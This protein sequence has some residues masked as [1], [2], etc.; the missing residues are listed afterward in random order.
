MAKTPKNNMDEEALI[1]RRDG[2]ADQHS[3]QPLDSDTRRALA[4]ARLQALAFSLGAPRS[5]T[6]EQREIEDAELLAYLLDLLPSDRRLLLEDAVR[7]DAH[8]FGRLMTLR[9][10]FNSETDKRD[11]QRANDPARN[12]T[13]HVLG[14]IE[15]RSFGD[16]LQFRE[17]LDSPQPTVIERS[18]PRAVRAAMPKRMEPR[19]LERRMYSR[20]RVPEW[21][22]GRISRSPKTGMMLGNLLDT[23]SRDWASARGLIDEIRSL[24]VQWDETSRRH[25]RTLRAWRDGTAGFEHAQTLEKKL[26]ASMQELQ[27]L[28]SQIQE[29]VR[30]SIGSVIST[31]DTPQD[32][33]VMFDLALE[34]TEALTS[35]VHPLARAAFVDEEWTETQ[36]LEVGRW[37]LELTGSARPTPEI[38]VTVR[39]E[40]EIGSDS[41]PFL[42]LIPMTKTTYKTS[43]SDS[44]GRDRFA[45]PL[46]ASILLIQ[47]DEIWQIP[48]MLRRE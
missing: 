5:A 13:R 11:R 47:S 39:G 28:T 9:S 44:A 17:A 1:R 19:F 8:A 33:S 3:E 31:P 37:T 48:L 21:P 29:R 20:E 32:L 15:I 34:E 46:G 6:G 2:V 18:V 40:G 43:E 7:A 45:L 10:T 24:V 38:T 25:D 41:R 27:H 16:K 35:I 22:A 26:V 42:T 4:D 14:Q 30:T 23:L 12:V 36:T